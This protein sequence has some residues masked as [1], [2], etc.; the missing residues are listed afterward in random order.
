MTGLDVTAFDAGQQSMPLCDASAPLLLPYRRP[1]PDDCKC[2]RPA[3][4]VR[5]E[6]SPL[7]CKRSN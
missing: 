2:E 7:A 3:P 4:S 1:L 5:D 6:L